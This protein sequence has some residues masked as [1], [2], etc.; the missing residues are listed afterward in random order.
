M[1]PTDF[2]Y[3]DHS[4]PGSRED[5]ARFRTIHRERHMRLPPVIIGKVAS[6]DARQMVLVEDHHM[7][8]ALPADTPD[9][10]LDI[11]VLPWTP[12]GDDNVLH[13][14][15]PDA[16]PKGC[17]GD[18]IAVTPQI[19]GCLA[20]WKRLDH[21]LRGPLCRRVLGDGE[22]HDAWRS[23]AS[24]KNTKS[25]RNVAVGTTKK[26]HDTRFLPW[27]CRNAFQVGEDGL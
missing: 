16:L 11:R 9:Q 12:W 13:T 19:P 25:T 26:S 3:R 7:I 14:H 20:P 1:E 5:G 15:V 22:M 18:A 8:Q 23:C 2:R 24:M 10:S 17:P 6:Q 4:A 21:L 27:L